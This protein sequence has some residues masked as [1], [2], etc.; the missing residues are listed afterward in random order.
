MTA[1]D[2]WPNKLKI[3]FSADV[4]YHGKRYLAE[5]FEEQR[6]GFYMAANAILVVNLA[7]IND[8]NGLGSIR[9]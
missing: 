1:V 4:G 9:P 5:E 2:T 3:V 6:F 7:V 8:L